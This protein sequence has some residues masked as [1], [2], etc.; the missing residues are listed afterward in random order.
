MPVGSHPR[1]NVVFDI[2]YQV[3][4]TVE[5][6]GR[7]L[8][9]TKR[10]LTWKFGF[11]H[12]PSVFPHLYDDDENYV[13]P[14]TTTTAS[15][16]TAIT[17]RRGGH[18]DGHDDGKNDDDPRLGGDDPP[19]RRPE[20]RGVDC[21]GREHEIMLTWSLLTGKAHIYVD[22]REIYRHVPSSGDGGGSLNPFAASFHKGFDLPDH[23]RNGRHRIDIRCYAC[24][25]LGARNMIVNDA[26]ETFHR[27]DLTVD[28]LSYFSMPAVFEL[29]T[30]RMWEK[31]SRWCMHDPGGGGDGVGGG[32][33]NGGGG[34]GGG[35]RHLYH[36]R[37]K[38]RLV[39]EYYF[40]KEK[41]KR[42]ADEI[43][44]GNDVV[45]GRSIST[46]EHRAM[47]PRTES[48]EERMV[49]I[50]L[51]ASLR[52]WEENHAAVV[53]GIG[54]PPPPRHVPSRKDERNYAKTL[55]S[56]GEDTNLI[57]FG[58][59]NFDDMAP[60]YVVSPDGP[61]DVS[62]MADDDAT[63]ASFFP[64]TTPSQSYVAGMERMYHPPTAYQRVQPPP[65]PQQQQQG[66]YQDPTFRPPSQLNQAQRPWSGVGTVSS[67][68]PITPRGMNTM[69]PPSDASF[70]VPPPPT[71][72]D[73]NN[74][75]GRFSEL[76]VAG[77]ASV[78]GGGGYTVT[79]GDPVMSP[80]S[81][82]SIGMGSPMVQQ[83]QQQQ[84][85]SVA[86]Y[87]MQQAPRW[88]L[89]SFEPT[90][91]GGGQVYVGGPFPSQMARGSNFDPLRSDPFAS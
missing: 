44:Y 18:D 56:I 76:S 36:G 50:A 33:G 73:Y 48:D 59:E 89:Q 3:D 32:G 13:G 72:D 90:A 37:A 15:P 46:S 71:W 83:Q 25:P 70:V 61:S 8:D 22:N 88:Q 35:D 77:G 40:D 58:D 14:P 65:P 80:M 5:S 27:Y 62:I 84:Q 85:H 60:N 81:N 19:R 87:G 68:T 57:D 16:S 74:A 38:G 23:R 34:G 45:G 79:S 9:I 11:A 20:R 75:F 26:G 49:R 86:Q 54:A 91:G 7:H 39:D 1:P 30:D 12:P 42:R 69:M 82:G 2:P 78:V 24:T 43:Y 55:T 17:E 64:T 51:E 4:F 53:P 41:A 31:V 47:T 28:G 6:R 66:Y 21:R 63:T 52:E 67:T 29:G 10:R